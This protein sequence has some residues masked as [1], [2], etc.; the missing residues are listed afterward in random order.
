MGLWTKLPSKNPHCN[1]A[2]FWTISPVFPQYAYVFTTTTTHLHTHPHT[3]CRIICKWRVRFYGDKSTWYRIMKGNRCIK[4]LN[5]IIPV[6]AHCREQ[7]DALELDAKETPSSASS[8]GHSGVGG[9]DG[10]DSAEKG[11]DDYVAGAA[12][13]WTG[14]AEI[15]DLWCVRA[16]AP[17][18]EC[19]A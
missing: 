14:K 19:A 6:I 1:Y 17:G 8:A 12:S 9:G 4:E 7:I 5:E 13:S 2:A 3:F 15:L 18:A 11:D 16:C 10:G